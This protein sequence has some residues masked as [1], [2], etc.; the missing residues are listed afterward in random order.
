MSFIFGCYCRTSPAHKH[1]DHRH[2]HN[3]ILY[4]ASFY[5]D[6]FQFYIKSKTDAG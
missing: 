3:A 6:G 1:F 2:F 5:G 4:R